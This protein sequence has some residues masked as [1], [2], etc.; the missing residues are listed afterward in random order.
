MATKNKVVEAQ[1][2]V[3]T[4]MPAEEESTEKVYTFK[5]PIEYN[6]KKYTTL[7]YDLE[8]LTG[9]DSMDVEAELV[10]LRKG[11][12]IEGSLNT[13]YIIRIFCK[14]CKE[15]IGADAF[16]YMSLKDYNRIKTLTRNFL[17]ESGR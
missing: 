17:M 5:K 9:Q 16:Q 13:D 1:E 12:V 10:R 6:G 14:A 2:N 8:S 15:K 3:Q 11:I 4:E 7:T